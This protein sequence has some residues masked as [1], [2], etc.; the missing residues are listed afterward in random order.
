MQA[1]E[2]ELQEYSEANVIGQLPVN[3][4]TRQLLVGEMKVRLQ[5]R[6]DRSIIQP[7]PTVSIDPSPPPT[8]NDEFIGL[9]YG[10]KF[11][12]SIEQVY[13]TIRVG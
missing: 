9:L 6:V 8:D 7:E 10:I 5:N 12:R 3:D 1:L 2:R 4:K 13:N 11:G